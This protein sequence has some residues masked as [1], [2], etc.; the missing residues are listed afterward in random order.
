MIGFRMKSSPPKSASRHTKNLYDL[1]R[2]LLLNNSHLK[3]FIER[4][5]SLKSQTLMKGKSSPKLPEEVNE[6]AFEYDLVVCERDPEHFSS[7]PI[8][9]F[10][11][12]GMKKWDQSKF[13]YEAFRWLTLAH[14]AM[15]N[16][17]IR[18]ES[19]GLLVW[20]PFKATIT[21][22]YLGE[23]RPGIITLS[24][25]SDTE[26][27]FDFEPEHEKISSS[28]MHGKMVFNR[29][30][31]HLFQ[32]WTHQKA[33]GEKLSEVLYDSGLVPK[34]LNIH[35]ITLSDAKRILFDN[36]KGYWEYTILQGEN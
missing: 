36:D 33:K 14:Q 3:L 35:F 13:V 27:S 22:A 7:K 24:M 26:D 1:E 32:I 5:F 31:I 18:Q 19:K 30:Q 34:S 29:P 11:L 25:D 4:N 12:T 8:A 6:K 23:G 28:P 15:G 20:D 21:D 2:S 10:E 17:S 9:F 16:K